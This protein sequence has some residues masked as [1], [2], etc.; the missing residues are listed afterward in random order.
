[1]SGIQSLG[2]GSGLLTSDLVDQ[3]VKAERA[4]TDLRLD[5]NEKRVEAQI[6]AYGKLK[7]AVDKMQI[8]SS[9]LANAQGIQRA[10]ARSS[11]ES[12]LTATTNSL[13]EDGFF[14]VNI[15]QTA[16]AH[17]LATKRFDAP[18]S[19]LGT[20]EI[21][22]SFG[23]ISY[24]AEGKP[25]GFAANTDKTSLE[26]D[27]NSQNNSL[28]G[29]RDAINRAD[30]GVRASIVNDGSGY[31]LL[32]SSAETGKDMAMNIDVIGDAGLQALAY[33]PLSNTDGQHMQQT[34]QGQDA[35]LTVNGLAISSSK[36][37]VDEVI[38]GVTLNLNQATTGPVNLTLERDV[39]G[40]VEQVE[41]F[42]ESYN[43]YRELYQSL[44]RFDP[45]AEAGGLLMGDSNLRTI[46]NQVRNLLGSMV[47]GLDDSGF[48]TLADIGITT[49]RNNSFNLRVDSARLETALRSEPRNVSGLL[50]SNLSAEQASDVTV[51]TK[52]EDTR[53]GSY[54]V[55][56]TQ[57]AE[58]A[59]WQG[60]S[61]SFLAF[62]EPLVIDGGN[63]SFRV[64]VDGRTAQ[65]NLS[66]GSY[67]TGD[68]LALM[69]QNSI[70]QS[71]TSG[72]SVSVVFD[73]DEQNLSITSS[74]FGSASE[75]S[76]LS[77]SPS[78]GNTLGLVPP[79]I[80]ELK[81]NSLAFLAE[82]AFGASTDP[83]QQEIRPDMG[84]NFE[85]NPVSF[86]LELSGSNDPAMNSSFNISLD[87]N[88]SNILDVDGEV[89][90]AR[91]REDVL[92]YIQGELNAAGLAGEVSAVF[93][94]NNRLQFITREQSGI[95]TL[96]LSNLSVG[97]SDVLGLQEQQVSSGFNVST[98][99]N[100]RLEIANRLGSASSEQINVPGGTYQTPEEVA[101]AIEN[102][103]NADPE[104]AGSASGALSG[105]GT[106][107]LGNS[108]NFEARSSSIAFNLNGMDYE[109][110]I[111]SNEATT[112]ES[113]QTALDAQVGPGLL[114]ARVMAGGGLQLATVDT[115]KDQQLTI[116]DSGRGASTELG[117]MLDASAIDF[118]AE[119]ATFSLR[120]DGI[121][122]DVTVDANTQAT[123]QT[124]LQAV[125]EALDR[126]LVNAD[127]G[128]KF[129]SGDV[130]AKVVE[131]A[132]E[133]KLIFETQSRMG[134]Q[135][136]TTFGAG[137]DIQ[138]TQVGLGASNDA[139]GLATG[140]VG[141]AGADGFGLPTGYYQGFDGQASVSFERNS[142]GN[143][144]FS[145]KFD[146]ETSVFIQDPSISS[147]VQLGLSATDESSF[148]PARGK[149][150]AGKINGVAANGRG[151]FLTAGA[152]NQAATNGYVLGGDAWNFSL[153][154]VVLDNSNRSFTLEVDGV[155]TN[156][157]DVASGVYSSGN[158]LAQ[159]MQSAINNDSNLQAASK[160]VNV[161]YDVNTGVFGI[162][163]TTRG[164]DSNVR[165]TDIEPQ[166]SE[167]FGLS[168]ATASV[169][170]QAASGEVN[171]AA[172]LM[173]RIDGNQQGSRGEVSYVRG[174]ADELSSLLDG[175][176]KRDG[177][178]NQ[179][180]KSLEK[181]QE[182]VLEQRSDLD[183]RM[184]VFRAR[185]A[186]QFSF[187]D[188]IISRLKTTEDFLVQQFDIMASAF[189][190]K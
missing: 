66:Q 26:L 25:E 20:G 39:K 188:R 108:V 83:A 167:V 143:G 142:A 169:R 111:D 164:T 37:Q 112:Q 129:I 16:Q 80:G 124:N 114:E 127:G 99:A 95:Q 97:G 57:I 140:G 1:M 123:G 69:I 177:L 100:F 91:D 172:G 121:D 49:D 106:R 146:N 77:T 73:A 42:V 138:I 132:G 125:Q 31:R 120:V 145:I 71:F 190:K 8:S 86:T 63:Y 62:D 92:N 51:V 58:Q 180:T 157:I 155:A 85:A 28:S 23:E 122:I 96:K 134:E 60:Q 171:P 29:I 40:V 105:M 150:V 159:A 65:V 5:T 184:E 56:V 10:T 36:N 13:A 11:N 154:P 2:I 103:I 35:L 45:S 156:Q 67:A 160:S 110:V 128:G 24:D 64:N 147:I 72:P 174:I 34:Q 17:T 84:L 78:M 181:E 185:L 133:P 183:R 43:E 15:Q 53:P 137:A 50:A 18:T 21:S 55:E 176:L 165:V 166:A 75:V 89:V 182:Q 141:Q 115:G 113:I 118:S 153:A 139:L 46:N 6:S 107:V 149:D 135:T 59:R 44:V 68:E 104:I 33:N 88:M 136:A 126:A 30:Q 61:T 102:A 14:S 179:R 130:I 7:S 22:I 175:I 109:V 74:R 70:N 54:D 47:E 131:D 178:L 79:G 41:D 4:A 151:Q 101:L 38:R 148:G 3:L 82:R 170:G 48:R 94:N 117:A 19:T 90:T 186:S 168:P 9:R 161:Q 32:L 162:F 189:G 81:G 93:N 116:L 158:A 27:I 52:T 12:A 173:L 187:N 163:S 119:P 98:A 87:Q 76:V 152:G 144:A